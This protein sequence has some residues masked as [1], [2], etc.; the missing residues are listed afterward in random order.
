MA[1]LNPLAMNVSSGQKFIQ[2]GRASSKGSMFAKDVIED[3]EGA[4]EDMAAL[5]TRLAV[6]GRDSAIRLADELTQ[7][8]KDAIR[9]HMPAPGWRPRESTDEPFEFSKGR[10][11]AAWGV[12]TP[13]DIRGTEDEETGEVDLQTKH[14]E[15]AQ[16]NGVAGE[17]EIIEGRDIGEEREINMGAVTEIKRVKG[18]IWTAE[19]GTFL[20]YA[21]LANDG[22]TM[23]IHP[24]GN[25][26]AAPVKARWEGVHYIEEGIAMTEA[27][28][29]DIV[30]GSLSQAL[31]GQTGRRKVKN[32]GRR[33]S[34]KRRG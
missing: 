23:M 3:F 19:V 12:Y 4:I 16:T 32:P 17:G 28:V 24:Y 22:G 13:E 20:P 25:T 5:S 7:N 29:D 14:E 10:L 34:R 31:E 27:S 18:N 33:A 11:V 30:A 6:V 26:R 8:T 1:D 2:H 21:G 9:S 15:W